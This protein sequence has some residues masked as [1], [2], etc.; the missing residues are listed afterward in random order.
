M[1][2]TDFVVRSANAGHKEDGAAT[3]LRRTFSFLHHLFVSLSRRVAQRA[4]PVGLWLLDQ[5]QIPTLAAV[6]ELHPVGQ[7]PAVLTT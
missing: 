7:K 6:P 5:Q 4:L 2:P 1:A 3:P